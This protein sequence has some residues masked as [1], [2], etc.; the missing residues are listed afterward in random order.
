MVR[1]A[2]VFLLLLGVACNTSQPPQ[3]RVPDKRLVIMGNK[4]DLPSDCGTEAVASKFLEFVDAWNEGD[5]EQIDNL[6][7]EEDAFRTAGVIQP[8]GRTGAATDNRESL[9]TFFESRHD[10]GE[11]VDMSVLAITEDLV[12]PGI[13]GPVVRIDFLGSR[14]ADDIEGSFGI[15]GWAR[16]DCAT[17]RFFLLNVGAKVEGEVIDWCPTPSPGSEDRIVACSTK[18]L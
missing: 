2:A 18:R 13:R 3:T 12:E 5:G 15:R 16:L 11:I 14:S 10:Q 9:P 4:A 6:F 8:G 1:Q 17:Q 7:A